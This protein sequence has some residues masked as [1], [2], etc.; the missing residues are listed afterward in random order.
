MKKFHL[1]MT[2]QPSLMTEGLRFDTCANA[3]KGASVT[4]IVLENR[5]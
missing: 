3:D 2:R 1:S 4:A 5:M